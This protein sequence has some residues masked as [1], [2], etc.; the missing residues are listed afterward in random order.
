MKAVPTRAVHYVLL[1][2]AYVW[3]HGRWPLELDNDRVC[4]DHSPEFWLALLGDGV[5]DVPVEYL[6]DTMWHK[7]SVDPRVQARVFELYGEPCCGKLHGEARYM[8]RTM[9]G[10]SGLRAAAIIYPDLTYYSVYNPRR[11]FTFPG[12]DF[13]GDAMNV[14]VPGVASLVLDRIAQL[15]QVD[16]SAARPVPT[17]ARRRT[18]NRRAPNRRTPNRRTPNTHARMHARTRTNAQHRQ[19]HGH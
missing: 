18:P 15:E 19:R 5:A 14:H 10:H 12:A 4:G 17:P 3:E 16:R 8:S 2:L 9:F 7:S 13:D 1:V 11:S 6:K